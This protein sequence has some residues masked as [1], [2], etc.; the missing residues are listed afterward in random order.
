MGR[1]GREAMRRWKISSPAAFDALRDPA[2]YFNHIDAHSTALVEQLARGD[3]ARH[4]GQRDLRFWIDQQSRSLLE[5][6]PHPPRE[7]TFLDDIGD[8]AIDPRGR[9]LAGRMP[10]RPHELWTLLEDPTVPAIL[11]QLELR[12][13]YET[14]PR[15][16]WIEQTNL[17]LP[18]FESENPGELVRVGVSV[19]QRSGNGQKR[20]SWASS[21]AAISKTRFRCSQTRRQPSGRGPAGGTSIAAKA[22]WSCRHGGTTAR[23]LTLTSW[24]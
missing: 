12:A 16:P 21:E 10:Q 3:L 9:F 8:E 13:W 7:H 1:F 22:G 6:M 11:F 23:S 18:L 5:S 2:A 17:P 4:G 24:P 20:L 19:G 15:A 14:L